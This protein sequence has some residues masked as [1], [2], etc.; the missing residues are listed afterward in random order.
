MTTDTRAVTK[1]ATDGSNW[2]IYRDRMTS[3]FKS[4][5]WASH[6]TSTTIPQ[7]YI[8]KGDVN[9]LTPDERWAREEEEAMDM[10]G[11]S[12][13]DDVFMAIKD[14]TTTMDTWNAVKDLFQNRSP[15]I[16]ADLR[17]KLSN[18]KLGEDED[19]RAFFNRLNSLRGQLASMGTIYTD[20]E[21]AAILLGSTSDAY[22]SV[23]G[24]LNAVAHT[25]G[26]P[27]TPSQ[28]T[29]LISDEYD[30][31]I[32]K[33]NKNN[34]DE[35]FTA[36]TQKRDMRKVECYNCHNFGHM[37]SECWAK[38]GDKEGQRPPR[39]NNANSNSN[40]N[41]NS[42]SDG[43][44]NRGGQNNR[45]NRNTNRNNRNNENRNTN[46]SA[47][48]AEPDIGAWAAIEEIEDEDSYTDAV[49]T[50]VSTVH[51]PGVEVELYDSGASRHMSPFR[52]R[53]RNFHPI[54]PRAI[55]SADHRVFYATGAG[56]LQIDVPNGDTTTP[57]IL[58]DTLY[59][60]DMALT[61][62]SISRINNAGCDVNFSAK[63]RTC[64][65]ISPAG[66]QIGC[67]PANEHGLFRVEHAYAAAVTT[68]VERVD[69]H[70][71]HRRLGHISADAIRALIRNH[72]IEGI[73][74][75][76][77]GS[78]II[79][80]SCEHAKM[81]R[82]IIL[83]ERKAP[84]AKR[85]GD[86]VHT[87]LWGPS[88]INSLGGRRY[89]ITFTDDATRFTV[90]NVLRTKD[91]A[92]NA[93]KTF[94]AWAQ[95]QHGAKIKALRSDR[96][97][98]FTSHDFTKF[99]QQE[100]TERRLTTHDTPQ[101]NGVAESLNRRL[102]ERT[103]A[104]LHHSDLPKNLW[105]EALRNSVWLKNRTSTKALPNNITPY[106]KLYGIKPDLS[107]VPEWGQHIWVH[108]G[109]GSKLDA[110]G[111]EARWI[112]FDADSTHAH[113]VYWPNKR[114]ISVER[115]V[116][117]SIPGYILYP[118][119]S[120]PYP[121]TQPPPPPPPGPP[122][123]APPAA[124]PAQPVQATQPVVIQPPA[125]PP[126]P[127]RQPTPGPSQ[128]PG[129]GAQTAPPFSLSPPLSRDSSR[130]PAMP[131]GM[132]PEAPE[133][134]LPPPRHPSRPG[135]GAPLPQPTR[136]SA[137]R[138]HPSAKEQAIQRGEATTGEEYDTPP[139]AAMRRW[140]HPDTPHYYDSGAY[141]SDFTYCDFAY[142]A[143]DEEIFEA[144]TSESQDDPKS[145]KEA[146][147]RSDWSKWQQ[148]MDREIST[149]ENAG[150]WIN[151]PRPTN[152]NIVGSKWVFRIKRKADGSIE[153]YKARLVAQGF[154]QKFG[155]DYFDTFSPVAKLSSFRIILAIAA[156]ND[157]DADTFD[158][159]GAYL[160]GELGDNEEIYMK[161]PPGYTS[162]GEQ[163]KRLLK[164]LY[165]LKQAGRKWYETLSRALLDLGF[166]VNNA[167]PGVFSSHVNNHTTILAI[168]VDDC[169][170]TG[171]SPELIADY[172]HKLNQRYSLTDL[173]PVHWLLG[174]KI[175][176]NRETRTISLSQTS[177]IDTVLSRF[178]LSNAKPLASPISPG[179]TLS[180]KDSPTDANEMAQMKK[181]PYR[182]AVGSLMYAAVATRPD[183]TFAISTLS[184]FL[185][186][187]G[188]LHWEAVKR[189]LRY[190]S[191]TKTH[192]LTYG[193]EHHD[194]H[195]YTD[196]DGASQ[197]H[198]HA[199]SGYAFLIDGAAISWASRK[200]E[201]VTLST[202]EAEY[203]AT[204]HAAKECI[205]LRRLTSQLFNNV[206][207]PTTLH[208]DNQAAIHLATDD[209]YHARTKHIDIRFHFI[210]QTI[211]DGAI[212]IV[213]CP[214]QDMTADILTKALPKHK[215]AIHS[216][217]LGICRT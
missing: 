139:S 1:L 60:P 215:V 40:S 6:L 39:R 97:G 186:N 36:S 48:A 56:D 199:I 114:S 58:R 172:K 13:P 165:G 108:S 123:A 38:G 132:Q 45:N 158:F 101:H 134:P 18:S 175:S 136:R 16:G 3:H 135:R 105:A 206:T 21:Y 117:F 83:K 55:A 65:I 33:K 111:L 192:A 185:E 178:S 61:I 59:A 30:R 47:N 118:E 144:S 54:P 44:N 138:P 64:K 208:C 154:T 92:L 200:Q 125:P 147:S 129:T 167:D 180:K 4:R 67:I 10:I 164:S 2:V 171:S 37:K 71:L 193:N 94:A 207:S 191:G 216:Q 24:G 140:M 210:R 51:Q 77:D 116:R 155:V 8:A 205:W 19:V 107:G 112:G 32:M 66:K 212:N 23:L 62:I 201:L 127:P 31:R 52:H 70:T 148:S 153:K 100:G 141:A 9:G 22:D 82:K 195:G 121:Q 20:A 73:D 122:P 214:T 110:R 120:H 188:L 161:P 106:E 128:P 203:V 119:S 63:S 15:L 84:P 5:H 126:A 187:P 197:D 102:L 78:P 160:N 156:R 152:K 53:F 157:W 109:T 35:A 143:A 202:A 115:D 174:I 93:Y 131:G 137:R 194:L 173:G 7:A 79:C 95:T 89:Y 198:R 159:N 74:L 90:A 163:V 50:T 43:R 184:Q 204:T 162:E 34:N 91:E 190:L 150:T 17:K 75:I 145:L 27:I 68:P 183:I 11:L 103:R 124:P 42:N 182:E 168:H 189:V 170:I 88:P 217:N 149:L 130:S 80:D 57:I 26:V 96:G 166:Q 99:L 69:I 169:L 49:Y 25:S 113:R 176:R 133:R 76:D 41:P 209:N 28:I 177:Y 14:N 151:V 86:E 213:Y 72:A 12:V 146:Q 85:F 29:L 181:V 98:E 104:V 211:M 87:D 46:D 179:V 196:A 142:L 81:T